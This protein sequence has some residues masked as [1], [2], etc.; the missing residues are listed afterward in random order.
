MDSLP[1][2]V[3]RPNPLGMPGQPLP[4]DI[5]ITGRLR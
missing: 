4:R 5:N 2:A 3:K 1:A